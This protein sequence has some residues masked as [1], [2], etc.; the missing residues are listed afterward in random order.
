M[1]TAAFL[2]YKDAIIDYLRSF[3][4]EFQRHGPAIEEIL[5]K[6][7]RAL[8]FRVLDMVLVHERTVPRLDQNFAAEEYKEEIQNQWSNLEVWFLGRG[9]GESEA[10]RL[11]DIT[12]GII[13]KIT[14]YAYRIAENQ[15]RSINRKNEYMY[16]CK[17]FAACKDVNEAHCLSAAVFGAF[18]TQHIAGDFERETDSI[19]SGVWD[20][21]AFKVETKPRT[22]QY[23]EKTFIGTIRNRE[24]EKRQALKEYLKI[25]QEEQEI[26]NRYIKENSIRFADLPEIEPFV[27]NT[28]LRWIG[29][30]LG[31]RDRMGKTED[32]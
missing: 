22:R 30:G 9:G 23:R 5:R 20:E 29:R 28:L 18:H 8:V 14:R 16:L 2:T 3:I 11:L 32:G 1:N 6:M 13:R 15:N 26:M 17:L 19:T 10:Y 21:A 7:D 25:Q 27:R 31:S 12:N 4:R 24:E